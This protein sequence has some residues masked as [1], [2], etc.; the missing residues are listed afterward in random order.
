MDADRI[1]L[2]AAV[3]N[4]YPNQNV[5]VIDLGSCITYDILDREGLHH[6]GVISPG[7]KC[8]IKHA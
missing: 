7:Y 5:L 3:C 8:V 4:E 2:L 1:A 6:G